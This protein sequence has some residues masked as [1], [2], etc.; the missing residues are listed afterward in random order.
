MKTA[1][2]IN[3]P[4]FYIKRARFMIGFGV[5]VGIPQEGV[6][7]EFGLTKLALYIKMKRLN[8]NES[9]CSYII[10]AH[11]ILKVTAIERS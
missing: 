10:K 6:M 4:T 11:H 1:V 3:I 7:V 8:L 9:F 5:M 2:T